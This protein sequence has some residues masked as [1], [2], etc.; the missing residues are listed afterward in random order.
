MTQNG[1]K[2]IQINLHHAKAASAILSKTF[3]QSELHVAFLQEPWVRNSRVLGISTHTCKLIYDN[4]VPMPRAA[5]L[6][7]NNIN[8]IPITEYI[9]RDIVAAIIEV[10]TTK[11]KTTIY[12]ATAN[13][14]GDV[15][16]IP[17]QE[18]A[19]FISYCKG[20]N[21]AFII[22][23]DANAH[24]T[25]W[26]STGTNQRGES[27]LQFISQHDIDIC[28]RG[29]SPTFI[30]SIREEVLDLTLCSSII[31]ENIK[32]WVVSDEISLSDH[33]HI[34]FNYAANNLIKA[35][36][37]NPRKTNWE[38]YT[39]KFECQM[40]LVPKKI[41][42]CWELE[43]VSHNLI[44]KMKEAYHSSCPE[45]KRSTNRNVSW[46]N[47][48]LRK[49]RKNARKLFNRAK[50]TAD[51]SSYREALTRYNLEIR[52]SKR[53]TWKS[54]CENIETIPICARLQKVLSK[55]HSN[56]LGFL[57]KEN[58][59]FTSST[60][61]TL[62][63]LIQAHFPGALPICGVMEAS[64]TS[65]CSDINSGTNE[66]QSGFITNDSQSHGT[67]SLEL[68]NNMFTNSRVEWAIDSLAP[69]KSPGID[70]IYPILLQKGKKIAVPALAELFKAS[71][72]FKFLPTDWRQSRV[73]FIPKANA[74]DKYSP[75]AFRPISL[76]SVFLKL[77]EKL[78]NVHI[79]DN[80]LY[81]MPLSK[82]QFAYQT[83]KSTITALHAMV[84][85]IEKSLEAK[86]ILLASFLDV[87][88][89]FNNVSYRSI[90]EALRKRCFDECIVEWIVEMLSKRVI[91]ASHGESSIRVGAAKGCPQGG[92]LS[93]LLWSLVADDLLNKLVESGFEVIGFA[94]DVV[95]IVRGKFDTIIVERMQSALNFTL[96]WCD[97]Q[98]LSIN[99]TKTTVIP[100]TKRKKFDVNSL[101]LGNTKLEL[102]TEVK[103]LG[104]TLDSK[105]SW[106]SHLDRILKKATSAFWACKRTFGKNWGLKPRMIHWIYSAIVKPRIMY[107]SLVWWPKTEQQSTQK[108]LDKILRLATM[109]I[110]GSMCTTPSNALNGLLNILPLHQDIKMDALKHAIRIQRSKQLITGDLVGHLRILKVIPINPL[111]LANDDRMEIRLD[112]S[113][114]FNVFETSR[115]EWE[116]GGPNLRN[117]STIFFTDGSKQNNKVGAG[118][119]GPG[120]N[121]SVPMG[122]WPTV[123]QAEVY[124]ILECTKICLKRN[125]RNCNI[126]I[127][128]DSQAAL[129]A[130]NSVSCSSNL[131][132]ECTKLLQQLT[133][134]NTVNLYWVPGHSG[135]EGNEKAD[136]LARIGSTMSFTGP[137]PFCGVS[138]CALKLE[139]RDWERKQVLRNWNEMV[140][141][142][143]SRLFIQPNAAKSRFLLKLNKKDLRT[144]TGLV[145]GHCPCKY[146]LKV[147][148]KL[149]DDS[150]RFCSQESESSEHLMCKCVV[151]FHKRRKHLDKGLLEPCEIWALSPYKVIKFIRDIIPNWEIA[152][153][154]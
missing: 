144:Y 142:R 100:F 13:F 150:C 44:T 124:A 37:R 14:P 49:L 69:F 19:D 46:W 59:L 154:D 141:A 48:K 15:D 67:E 88:G 28:N 7:N 79:K 10:P 51:W 134:R 43:K 147:I 110:T 33:K 82:H 96:A 125:Y 52:K 109:S 132:W 143:Q 153:N 130:L 22:G 34:L 101:H 6:V 97:S 118:I 24:H 41:S 138:M 137:E 83:G 31:S 11:G 81:K 3:T 128:S 29:D 23:C 121:L 89:A 16:D 70:G 114:S 62:E 113:H 106:N 123:F 4:T 90:E 36:Y 99:P 92:V 111:F 120:I 63:T 25:V 102:S 35:T 39:S 122:E 119:T 131:V 148:G 47:E 38:S 12:V 18:V 139:L 105:L 152:F 75:K 74:K 87:E 2:F 145:T 93:P 86:E 8:C 140:E 60:H 115:V 68:A 91:S 129:K 84:H 108:K 94:D 45:K 103:Y 126:C 76:A 17:P 112:F 78:I 117:G 116:H 151:L 66:V 127:F 54:V 77:M 95:I 42:S 1:V 64:D 72:L 98:G 21:K 133:E 71:L 85:K 104:V 50:R 57:K 40:E 56:G 61:E 27:L 135:I 30:N 26:N 53:N 107:A 55:D 32:N 149:Q 136:E 80:I 9:K 5:L 65:S 146:H 73:V 20:K 58:G